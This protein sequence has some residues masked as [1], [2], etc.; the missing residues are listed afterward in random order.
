MSKVM[1]FIFCE[2]QSGDFW[3][4]SVSVVDIRMASFLHHQSK[5]GIHVFGYVCEWH[6]L[7]A[8][9]MTCAN[10]VLGEV[11]TI[12]FYSAFRQPGIDMG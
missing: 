2:G 4:L 8:V 1:L 7:H 11:T 5:D 12:A 6:C 9:I 3:S 10:A